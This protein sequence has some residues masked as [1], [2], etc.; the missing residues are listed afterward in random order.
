VPKG[1]NR[2]EKSIH[3][4]DKSSLALDRLRVPQ[5]QLDVVSHECRKRWDVFRVEG[6]E[7]RADVVGGIHN[8]GRFWSAHVGG[9]DVKEAGP[10]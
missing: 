8:A 1:A 6:S 5:A 9:F 2:A 4:A 3:G 7:D 10:S